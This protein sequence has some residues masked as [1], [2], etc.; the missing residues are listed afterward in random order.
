MKRI[1]C[2]YKGFDFSAFFQGTGK[3][4]VSVSRQPY[5]DGANHNMWQSAGFEEHLDY[6]RPED[7]NSPLGPNVNSYYPRPLFG[8]GWKNFITQTRWL[9]D[10]SYVRLKNI[11][12]GYTLPSHIVERASISKFRVYVSA[13][14]MITWT[15]MTKIFDP[16]TY[17]GGWGNGKIYP[18][19]KVVSAGINITF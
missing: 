7:T 16:E 15:S 12:L 2:Q 1:D 17:G 13:E 3:R 19:S 11:Q 4:D 6:F 8:A 5:F 14:N 18:L 9:Q 10:G